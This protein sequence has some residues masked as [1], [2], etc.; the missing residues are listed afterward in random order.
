MTLWR[1]EWLRV[2]RTQRWAILLAVF[3]VFGFLGPLAVRYLP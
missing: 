2:W 1:L 3:G